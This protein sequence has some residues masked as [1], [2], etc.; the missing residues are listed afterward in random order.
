MGIWQPAAS[1]FGVKGVKVW[2]SSSGRSL[3]EDHSIHISHHKNLKLHMVLIKLLCI[4]HPQASDFADLTSKINNYFRQ[5]Q[6][7]TK[8]RYI[9]NL[10]TA[11]VC[12][13]TSCS[14]AGVYLNLQ[15]I[16]TAKKEAVCCCRWH[17]AHHHRAEDNTPS[18]THQPQSF[19]THSRVST[20]VRST[21][22]WKVCS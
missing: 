12:V 3:T 4:M 10:V 20:V 7:T 2:V 1:F 16:S 13:I 6:Q 22:D 18:P 19:L 11:D 14:T 9:I 15:G 21:A 8:G 17:T 5:A